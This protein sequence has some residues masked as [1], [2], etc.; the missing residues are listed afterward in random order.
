MLGRNHHFEHYAH[1]LHGIQRLYAALD[2]VPEIY[3]VKAHSGIKGNEM[4]D[5]EAKRAAHAAASLPPDDPTLLSIDDETS[6]LSTQSALTRCRE[7]WNNQWVNPAQSHIH[8]HT[9]QLLPTI[10][11]ATELF[12]SVLVKL[13]TP[14]R[15]LI[16]RLLSGHVKLDDYMETISISPSP[17]CAYCSTKGNDIEETIEHFLLDCG[18]FAAQREALKE[19]IFNLCGKNELSLQLLLT[20]QPCKDKNERRTIIRLTAEFVTATNRLAA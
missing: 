20:G 18:V 17:Y 4:A 15:R 19:K 16:M 12:H 2:N 10:D 1:A 8:E 9:K 6:F 5:R 11:D 14:H 3:W 13:R 7:Q